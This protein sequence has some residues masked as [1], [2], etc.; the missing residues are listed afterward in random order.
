MIMRLSL[1]PPRYVANS[2]QIFGKNRLRQD[3]KIIRFVLTLMT[4][5]IL[6]V[7]AVGC[8]TTAPTAQTGPDA[9]LSFDGLHRYDNTRVDAAWAVPHLNL[10]RYT[11]ILPVNLGIEYREVT[12]KGATS[13]A[14]SRGGPYFIDD[15]SRAQFEALV[16][17]IV[18]EEL[19]KSNRFDVVDERGPD[20]LIIG[21]ALLNV[22]SQVPPRSV[23]G[24]SRI[25][26]RSVGEATLV[27]EVRNSET[28][29]ILARAVD[30]RAASTIGG[31]FTQSNSVTTSAEVRR[32]IRFWASGL[33]E[34]LEG[35][36]R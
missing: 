33:R 25:Y 18:M 11:K 28:N 15:K 12:N 34:A 17:Q 9:E 32:L 27:L 14:R 16:N 6:V 30:R 22:T 24:R 31:S 26:L 29:A 1:V 23:S 8:T 7:A 10:S 3:M 20:T 5:F 4:A 36:A 13:V 2:K 19:Q 35:F 21:G